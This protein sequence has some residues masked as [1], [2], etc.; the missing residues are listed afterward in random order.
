MI[1]TNGKL[2]AWKRILRG[3]LIAVMIIVTVIDL[4]VFIVAGL[5]QLTSFITENR[6][7][8]YVL[9]HHD[10]MTVYASQLHEKAEQNAVDTYQKWETSWYPK[11]AE[12]A[13]IVQFVCRS[14]GIAPSTH[15]EGVYYSSDGKPYDF[16]RAGM[17]LDHSESKCIGFGWYWYKIIT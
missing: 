1:E 17:T 10:E 5:P 13:Y 12:D 16:S 7:M 6:M 9:A 3:I 14:W 15:Y 8:C 4:L 11:E 2:P